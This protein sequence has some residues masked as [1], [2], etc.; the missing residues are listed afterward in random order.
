MSIVETFKKEFV[1]CTYCSTLINCTVY[2][3]FNQVII[4]FNVQ[5]IIFFLY[6]IMFSLYELILSLIPFFFFFGDHANIAQSA[7]KC[8]VHLV[9]ASFYKKD[10]NLYAILHTL[11]SLQLPI[12]YSKL[13]LADQNYPHG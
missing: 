3:Q 8:T 1:Q 4:L 11:K 13:N 6:N 2:M 5:I 9:H 10:K 12:L 7:L